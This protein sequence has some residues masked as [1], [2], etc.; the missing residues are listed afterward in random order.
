MAIEETSVSRPGKVV[1]GGCGWGRREAV[2]GAGER[3][4]V[5]TSI[6]SRR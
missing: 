6:Q 4:L 3:Y 2:V 1:V 5:I